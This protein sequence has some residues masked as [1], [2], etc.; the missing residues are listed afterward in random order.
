MNHSRNCLLSYENIGRRDQVLVYEYKS[1][2]CCQQNLS[3]KR[4]SEKFAYFVDSVLGKD[5]KYLNLHYS[6][7]Y[8]GYVFDL[9]Y[10]IEKDGIYKKGKIYT[11]RIRTVKRDL[12][13][14]F[15]SK[16]SFHETEE[17]RGVGG[18]L[19]IVSKRPLDQIYT[20]TPILIK[21]NFGYWRG[22]MTLPEFEE[23]L[24]VNLIKKY[25]FFSGKDIDEDFML[26][27]FMEFQNKGP[28]KISYKG[29]NFL[30]DKISF[31]VANNPTAQELAYLAI[32]VGVGENNSRGCGFINY[33]YL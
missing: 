28:I 18:E 8:K 21:N 32:G 27:D 16:L 1:R 6:I 3:Y 2:I 26:Y 20:V 9:P 24:K 11:V 22:H 4:V 15:S 12:A 13:E 7:N 10:E 5:E 25:K 29:I 33:K 31:Q 23:H 17:F 30:G 19:R 14:Y